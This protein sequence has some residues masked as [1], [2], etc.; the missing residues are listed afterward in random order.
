MDIN[1]LIATY[2]RDHE[3][4]YGT[5]CA[6]V[7]FDALDEYEAD[8]LTTVEEWLGGDEDGLALRLRLVGLFSTLAERLE[9]AEREE[10]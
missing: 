4:V 9:A 5:S 6:T 8:V 7:A 1:E 2:K 10:A 3:R